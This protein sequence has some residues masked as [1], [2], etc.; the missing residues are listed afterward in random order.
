[1]R[2]VGVSDKIIMRCKRF[3]ILYPDIK[4]VDP[5]R[6]FDSYVASFEKGYISKKKQSKRK[7]K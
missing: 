1:M 3:R 4:M 6:S 2:D 7:E 5:D